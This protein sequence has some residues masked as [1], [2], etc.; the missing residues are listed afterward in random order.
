MTENLAEMLKM[1][2]PIEGELPTKQYKVD[3]KNG[4]LIIAIK[5][6]EET[7]P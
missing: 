4:W 3:I 5:I 2:L 6:E 1:L 7:Q